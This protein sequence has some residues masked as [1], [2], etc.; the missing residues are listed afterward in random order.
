MKDKGRGTRLD[1][2]LENGVTINW[3]RSGK[4]NFRECRKNESL[5]YRKEGC[6]NL[7]KLTLKGKGQR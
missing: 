4:V 7:G 2:G 5:S 3:A 1:K 6:W